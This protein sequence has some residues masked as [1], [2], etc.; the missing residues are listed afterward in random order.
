M[1]RQ[2]ECGAMAGSAS[3]LCLECSIQKGL[4]LRDRDIAAIELFFYVVPVE[5]RSPHAKESSKLA[6]A[7]HLAALSRACER[8]PE[9]CIPLA[10]G[11]RAVTLCGTVAA[12]HVLEELARTRL[13]L[14]KVR[15]PH[16]EQRCPAPPTF[17]EGSCPPQ[18]FGGGGGGMDLAVDLDAK[19]PLRLR[20][21]LALLV[22]QHLVHA[23]AG[24]A[25]ASHAKVP[26]G[27]GAIEADPGCTAWWLP[28]PRARWMQRLAG[29]SGDER[30]GGGR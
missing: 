6:F 27:L 14:T 23:A 24:R 5:R 9:L 18:P 2:D 30:S 7:F 16:E 15:F 13:Q 10:C 21:Q 1:S 17:N 11:A 22:F 8:S 25:P 20:V 19:R 12:V 29:C 28:V 26:I 4:I 3:Y